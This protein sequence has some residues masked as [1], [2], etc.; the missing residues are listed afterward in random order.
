M[1]ITVDVAPGLVDGLALSG[2][3]LPFCFRIWRILP[4]AKTAIEACRGVSNYVYLLVGHWGGEGRGRV[5]VVTSCLFSSCFLSASMRGRFN[6]DYID[7]DLG[8][9][10]WDLA[11]TGSCGFHLLI[12]VISHCVMMLRCFF[13]PARVDLLAWQVNLLE[14]KYHLR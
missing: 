11:W 3:A 7:W 5:Q 10:I 4:G 14:K 1:F 6:L 8:F 9:G 12:L 2:G 13:S